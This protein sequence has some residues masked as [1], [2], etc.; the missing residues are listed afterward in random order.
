ME[1]DASLLRFAQNCFTGR[2]SARSFWVGDVVT[3]RPGGPCAIGA[4]SSERKNY[5]ENDERHN[6]DCFYCG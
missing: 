1:F 2:I 6:R 3:E 5:G 4:L